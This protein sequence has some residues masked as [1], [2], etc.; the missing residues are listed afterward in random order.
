MSMSA[1]GFQ[2]PDNGPSYYKFSDSVLYRFNINNRAVWMEIPIMQ[3]DFVFQTAAAPQPDVR[4][5]L[6]NAQGHRRPGDLPVPDLHVIVIRNLKTGTGT[7]YLQRR[8]R[9]RAFR[10]AAESGPEIDAE[11]MKRLS[12]SHRCSL[13]SNGMRVFAG[14]RDD[15]F[16]FDSARDVR[17][18]E[19]PRAR[20]GSDR[21]G[22]Y[23]SRRRP[24]R[25]PWM[26]SRATTSA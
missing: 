11:L 15:A 7:Y 19:L 13:L 21:R 25:T 5:V 26:V 20:S 22:R 1:Q 17:Y 8:E 6:R 18:P 24:I 12:A 2:N 9:P 23:R 4:L 10:R 3:I 16:Y 14:P